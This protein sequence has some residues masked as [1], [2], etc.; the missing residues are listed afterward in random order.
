M[1]TKN[2]ATPTARNFHPE[3]GY[4]CPSTRMRR[5][6]RRIA[7]TA[8]AGMAMAIGSALAVSSVLPPLP[9]GEIMRE[10]P[11]PLAV[12][13]LRP[14]GSVQE[15]HSP[16]TPTSVSPEIQVT[17]PSAPAHPQAS[18]DDLAASFLV[19]RC[20]FGTSGR[21]HMTRASRAAHA[22]SHRV[23]TTLNGRIDIAV[24]AEPD[25]AAAAPATVAANEAPTPPTEKP[26]A[27]AK[28]PITTA[29]K[30]GPNRNAGAGT[31]AATSPAPA[32]PSEFGPFRLFRELAHR[33]NDSLAMSFRVP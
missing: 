19:S 23:A 12:A 4:F 31:P 17:D 6:V 32:A 11:A 8:L 20:Q 14:I 29:H 16:T 33:G 22:A 26:A 3:F 24:A 27:Q 9:S 7:L 30:Q 2:A 21:S 28:K 10:E 13:V 18:C 5:K 1:S 15:R 25:R